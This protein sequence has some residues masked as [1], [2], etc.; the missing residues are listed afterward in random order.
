MGFSGKR[1]S[2][3]RKVNE[4]VHIYL[5]SLKRNKRQLQH[6][7]PDRFSLENSH[8]CCRFHGRPAKLR[9]N[10]G[11]NKFVNKISAIFI[12]RLFILWS[13]L[14]QS[15]VLSFNVYN[16]KSIFTIFDSN[17]SR[18]TRGGDG[19]YKNKA[20]IDQYFFPIEN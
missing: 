20:R 9:S 5:R 11:E 14:K 2:G 10:K 6:C 19:L 8:D 15:E 7:R 17:S 4:P 18:C 16:Y 1:S 13:T 3:P 12:L